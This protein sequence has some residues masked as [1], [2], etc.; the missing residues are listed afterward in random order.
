LETLQSPKVF[1]EGG[2]PGLCESLCES[3]DIQGNY[4][5]MDSDT[6]LSELRHLELRL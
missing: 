5:N 3:W 2:A 6:D 1:G 4:V